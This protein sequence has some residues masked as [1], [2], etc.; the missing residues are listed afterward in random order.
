MEWRL[1]D[2]HR[3]D[4]AVIEPT[5]NKPIALF[6]LKRE[7]NQRTFQMAKHQLE[8]Y[9]QAL[10]DEKVPTYIVFPKDGEP[11]FELYSLKSE[12]TA[13]DEYSTTKIDKI[14]DYSLLKSTKIRKESIEKEKQRKRTF[15]WF[16]LVCFIIALAL[17]GLLYLDHIEKWK[18]NTERLVLIG[19]VIG[20]VVVPFASKLKVL[21]L[22]FERFQSKEENIQK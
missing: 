11:P 12:E 4:L 13:N 8:A 22:E 7:N 6:E 9:S 3:V 15:N 1:G 16:Q 2:R 14:P 10:G 5:T 18:L 20:L 21:G 19:I 17:A